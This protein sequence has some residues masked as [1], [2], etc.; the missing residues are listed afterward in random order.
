MNKY[1]KLILCVALTLSV[2]AIAG[3]ATAKNIYGWYSDLEKP[4]FN[5]PNYLFGPVWTLLYIL[6]GISFFLLLQSPQS[7]KRKEAIITFYVQLFLNF[8]WSFIFFYFQLTGPA[9]A[10]ILVLW[11]SILWMLVSFK[12]INT[13]AA[14]LQL[15]YLLW[16]SFASVLN[17]SIWWLN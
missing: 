6:M 14:I 3:I 17:A 7:N 15:P 10:E 2:G 16:V 12:K 1:L 9:L 4:S 11:L 8:C 13:A 5:P